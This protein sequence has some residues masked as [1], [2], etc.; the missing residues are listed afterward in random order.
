[1]LG[2]GMA[3]ISAVMFGLL[4]SG[5]HVLFVNQTYG[6][7]LQLADA[8]RR[9]GISYDLVVDLDVDALE[10]H[11]RAGQTHSSGS[12]VQAQCCFGSWTSRR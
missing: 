4:E 7:T 6:P 2:S 3:A 8:L 11:I 9:F 12:R 5:D 1:M 10:L